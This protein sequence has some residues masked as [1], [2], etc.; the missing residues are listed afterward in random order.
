MTRHLIQ[1]GFGCNNQCAF[2]AQGELRIGHVQSVSVADQL[3]QAQEDSSAEV[4]FVG[5]EPSTQPHIMD[6]VLEASQMGF[7]TIGMQTNGRR[8]ADRVF[9]DSLKAGGL[10]TLDIS[11]MGAEHHSHDYHTGIVGSHTE[12]IEGIKN[13]VSEQLPV[14]IT[15]VVTRSNYRELTQLIDYCASLKVSAVHLSFIQEFGRAHSHFL[16]LVPRFQMVLPHLA[17]AAR[18]ARSHGLPLFLSGA[19]LCIMGASAPAALEVLHGAQEKGHFVT[20]CDGCTLQSMCPGIGFSYEQRFGCG[21]FKAMNVSTSSIRSQA[22]KLS[23]VHRLFAGI[24]SV[25]ST[26]NG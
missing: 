4:F 22:Q 25:E 5:G 24:G 16:Q 7:G 19:P 18:H 23:S 14:G 11:L 6:W 26:A 1:T 10:S 3:K 17:S 9:L 12:T 8:L 2:C 20:E 13:S 15:T 21:E